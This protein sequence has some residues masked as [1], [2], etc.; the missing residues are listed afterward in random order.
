VNPLLGSSSRMSGECEDCEK[1]GDDVADRLR[2]IVKVIVA[3]VLH[4]GSVR[5][6]PDLQVHVL[7]KVCSP[8]T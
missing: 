8:R 1:L 6:H 4:V 2:C 5:F 7:D 3:L